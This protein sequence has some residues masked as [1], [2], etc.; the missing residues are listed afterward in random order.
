MSPLTLL[1]LRTF[2]CDQTYV[3]NL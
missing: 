2:R 3:L 1:E